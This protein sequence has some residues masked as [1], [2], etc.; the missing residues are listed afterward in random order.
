MSDGNVLLP[1][2]PMI[3]PLSSLQYCRSSVV[4][5]IS[6]VVELLS[7]SGPG[8]GTITPWSCTPCFEDRRV[9][10]IAHR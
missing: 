4:G 5:C 9:C 6:L 8:V 3:R 2:C 10:N 7:Q 1:T